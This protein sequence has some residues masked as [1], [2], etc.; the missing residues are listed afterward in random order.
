MTIKHHH[1]PSLLLPLALP[2]SPRFRTMMSYPCYSVQHDPWATNMFSNPDLMI[3]G[4]PA[5]TLTE[6]NAREIRENMVRFL[7][8]QSMLVV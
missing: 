1:Y 2:S 7:C 8:H 3:E 6:N 4:V 5:G